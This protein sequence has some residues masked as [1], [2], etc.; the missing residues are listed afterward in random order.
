[1]QPKRRRMTYANVTAT[2]ALVFAIAGGTAYAAHHYLIS[3]T[4]QFK[5]S[6][7]K[8]LRGK[9]GPAG[10]AGRAGATGATGATGANLT[11]TTPLASGQTETGVWAVA[12]S[13]SSSSLMNTTVAFR[14]PLSAFV[15]TSDTHYEGYGVTTASC[16]SSNPPTAT[17]NQLCF[18]QTSPSAVTF[19]DIVDPVTN[20]PGGGT[21][22]VELNFT[23]ASNDQFARG[24]WAYMAP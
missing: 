8:S 17:A 1:M 6:V 7:L 9:I 23:L 3:S 14:P 4:K 18:Y 24:S 15:P 20:T 19:N 5:P 2:L 16:P 10:S 12:G 21:L 13:S 22:G 11:F